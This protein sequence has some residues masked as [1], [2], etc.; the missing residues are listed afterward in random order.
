MPRTRTIPILLV[1]LAA[2]ARPPASLAAPGEALRPCPSTPNCVSTEARDQR[3]GMQAVP[4]RGTPEAAQRH[5][6][7]ALLQDPRTRVVMDAPGYLRAEARSRVF[8]FVDDVEVVVD[9]AARVVRFRSASRVGR[10]DLGVNRRR[11]QRFTER[12]RALDAAVGTAGSAGAD[13]RAQI[14]AVIDHGLQATRDQDIDAYMSTV[15]ADLVIHDES[16]ELVTRDRLRA[17]ILRDWS[18]IP[19]TLRLAVRIDSLGV[20]GDTAATVYTFQEWERL[21]R[22][23]T[24]TKL[25][26]V[27]TTQRHREHWRRAAE[28]WRQYTI[29]ELGGTV[30]VNGRP[31]P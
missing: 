6:R 21:M 5:A 29:E 27:L 13:V 20:H 19:G 17:N 28:G 1:L 26:T 4:F 12:F 14:Q 15:P 8:R 24:G 9:G 2:C 11:M 23:R 31:Y 22:Q 30:R 16:G 18:I 3:H 10:S 7:Q 25:D